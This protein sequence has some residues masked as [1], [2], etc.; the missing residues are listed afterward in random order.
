[1]KN[2]D[3]VIISAFLITFCTSFVIGLINGKHDQKDTLKFVALSNLSIK[4]YRSSTFL[5]LT[6]NGTETHLFDV[7]TDALNKNPSLL[8][9]D[10]QLA[11]LFSLRDHK[12]IIFATI[13]GGSGAITLK[14]IA[15]KGKLQGKNMVLPF[16]LD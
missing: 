6:C 9:K 2:T 5:S 3:K 14:S 10:N 15:E 11:T 12:E 13:G 4:K 8:S 7:E 1:M 16:L